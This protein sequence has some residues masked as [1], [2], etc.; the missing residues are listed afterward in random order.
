MRFALPSNPTVSSFVCAVVSAFVIG[1]ALTGC[2]A[3][4]EIK[5]ERAGTNLVLRWAGAASNVV[6]ETA[7]RLEVS[8]NWTV[9]TN[10]SLIQGEDRVLTNWIG[11]GSKFYHLAEQ[12]D[13]YGKPIRFVKLFGQRHWG[14][15]SPGRVTG[16]KIFH[17]AGVV[18]DRASSSDHIYV[19]DTGNNRI[20]GFHSYASTNADL[21]FGQ[22][23]QFSGAANADG[24]LGF[25]GPT[26]RTNLC[27]LNYPEN[28]NVAEQWMRLNFDVD[29]GGNLYI[30]DSYNNRV[31]VYNAPS[32]TTNQMA[33]ETTSPTE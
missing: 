5:A 15:T 3:V 17:S 29:D 31:V 23:D 30:P 13:F 1:S 33:K 18:V 14:D 28:P 16:A 32:V 19:A 2:C 6:V 12:F 10:R 8:N 24:N 11:P 22:P 4:P 27:L 7:N 9:L 20:L 25:H 26:T 21:V